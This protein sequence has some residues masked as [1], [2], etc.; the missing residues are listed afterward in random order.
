MKSFAM[1]DIGKKRREIKL[2]ETYQEQAK[3]N[4][5]KWKIHSENYY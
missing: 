2:D 3:K 5:V 1:G 4:Y